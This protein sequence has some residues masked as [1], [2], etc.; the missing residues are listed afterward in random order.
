MSVWN[1]GNVAPFIPEI[2]GSIIQMAAEAKLVFAQRVD[3]RFEAELTNGDTIRIPIL[4]DF[5][6]AD[7]INVDA[8]LS[9]YST[10][11]TCTNV[12]VN[13]FFQKSVQLGEQEQVQDYP[14][15]LVAALKKCGHS[16]ASMIDDKLADLVTS[17][18]TNAIGIKGDAL[19]ADTL[20]EAYEKLNLQDAPDDDRSWIFDPESITDLLKLD[21]FIRA[22]YV[23]EGVVT[24]G[25]Q[26]RTIF[27]A[28]V[29]MTTNLNSDGTYHECA[30]FHREALALVSQMQPEVFRFPWPQRFS[31]VVGVK[32]LFGVLA[33]REAFGCIINSRS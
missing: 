7:A 28:P 8:D 32:A 27:G 3:R 11:Q 24:R 9:T 19:T 4:A 5:G 10:D 14:D 16:V 29:Y 21:Y 26:G 1:A 25:W 15:I 31:Q 33:A 6:D 30:Y 2:W 17:F 18:S 23:P 22:D 13:Y 20:I 12:V